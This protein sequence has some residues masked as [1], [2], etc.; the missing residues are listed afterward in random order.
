VK[1][2]CVYGIQTVL[3]F[4]L[5]AILFPFLITHRNIRMHLWNSS[6]KFTS[7]LLGVAIKGT[8]LIIPEYRNGTGTVGMSTSEHKECFRSNFE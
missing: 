6:H 2:E 7:I 5:S 1:T 4:P 8:N 3:K